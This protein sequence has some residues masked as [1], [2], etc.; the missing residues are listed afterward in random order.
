VNFSQVQYSFDEGGEF[1]QVSLLL[2]NPSSFDITVFVMSSYI[3]VTS[4]DC[5]KHLE[6][7]NAHLYGGY[8][9]TFP[10][11]ETV[12]FVNIPICDKSVLEEDEIFNLTIVAN[13]H[14]DNVTNGHPD[15]VTIA[16]NRKCFTYI[17]YFYLF[18]CFFFSYYCA[19]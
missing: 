5:S 12:Q 15:L 3:T 6:S 16:I 8:N 1:A 13:S 17:S 11:N 4:G 14:P 9:V 7:N 18:L 2:S 19:V 10:A